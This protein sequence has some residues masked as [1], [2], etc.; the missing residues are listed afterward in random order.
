MNRMAPI[1]AALLALGAILT[2]I[3]PLAGCIVAGLGALWQL[4]V[5]VGTTML[6]KPDPNAN[7]G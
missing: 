6:T 7:L 2:T 1:A 3:S 4:V 5:T